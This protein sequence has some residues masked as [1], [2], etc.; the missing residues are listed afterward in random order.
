[1]ISSEEYA[2]KGGIICPK[3]ESTD[4]VGGSVNIEEGTATQPMSCNGCGAAWDDIY[5]LVGYEN[6]EE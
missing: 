3:C 4:I 2:G 6:F 5:D 1:M